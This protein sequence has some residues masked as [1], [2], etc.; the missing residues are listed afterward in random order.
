MA[1]KVKCKR[2]LEAIRRP[3]APTVIQGTNEVSAMVT[4][5][6]ATGAVANALSFSRTAMRELVRGRWRIE[7]DRID[8]DSEGRGEVLY[9]LVGHGWTFHF[10]LVSYKLPEEQK[11][12]R[13]FA[14]SWDAMGVLCQGEWTSERE[15]YLRRE[16][17]KQ[18]AGRADYDT[19]VYARGNRSGRLFDHVVESLAA[20]QQPDAEKLAQIG[21]ILRTTAFIGNGQLGTRPLAG[22][23]PNHPMRRP[24]H[25][26]MWSAF[27]LREYVFDLV[28]HLARVSNPKAASLA[29]N[30]RR[31]LGLGNSAAT[32]LVPFIVN[33]PLLIH[34]WWKARESASA[35][36]RAQPVQPN[37]EEALR[38]ERLLVKASRYF[39][40]GN[41]S[42]DLAFASAQQVAGELGQLTCLFGE[43]RMSGTIAGQ[44]AEFPWQSIHDW[45][46]DHACAE[47]SDVFAAILLELYPAIVER[48][49]DSGLIDERLQVDPTMTVAQLTRILSLRYPWA[50]PGKG[51]SASAATYFWY[52]SAHA[53]R[54]LRRGLRDLA[55]EFEAETP[56]DVTLRV[57]ELLKCLEDQDPKMQVVDLLSAH[58]RLRHIV[59]RVQALAK[60]DQGE[61]EVDF[62]ARDFSPFAAI[63]FVLAF[64][65]MEKF[66]SAPPKS[67]RGAF[68]QG[69]P[70]G[71]D[72]E[73]GLDGNW[74]FPLAP[75]KASVHPTPSS[76]RPRSPAQ[77][78]S[79][80]AVD[81]SATPLPYS[82]T[83]DPLVVAPIE[84]LR[85]LQNAL[86][87]G[88]VDLGTA[89]EGAEMIL[90]HQGLHGG[91][92][93]SLLRQLDRGQRH[94][95]A[96][97]GR[98]GRHT[99]IQD[100][101][102]LSAVAVAPI[103]LDMACANALGNAGIGLSL[104]LRAAEPRVVGE[105]AKRSAERGLLGLLISQDE[106][107]NIVLT[108]PGNPGPWMIDATISE[109]A[110]LY[111][112]FRPVAAQPGEP[113]P[114]AMTRLDEMVAEIGS[115]AG[116]PA[117]IRDV[118]SKYLVAPH[119]GDRT[120]RDGPSPVPASG[121]LL[122][123]LRLQPPVTSDALFA[124]LLSWQDAALSRG[125]LREARCW[126]P[127]ELRKV[128]LSWQSHGVR[129]PVAEFEALTS[130][131][132]KL[133]VPV[134]EEHRLRP[135][136]GTDPLK[137]F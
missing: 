34:S 67:V 103:A 78:A 29:A 104:A 129:I 81:R 135:G 79:Q 108:G 109:A 72:V 9:R 47:T 57:R 124:S 42:S 2:L 32:G 116:N 136:E 73:H 48:H 43:Y 82:G 71:E 87:A 118:L 22:F 88:G 131:A 63:R 97:A 95:Q 19:L 115:A 76:T 25:A 93:G 137:V 44:K 65:G 13:N 105:I 91:A 26:Q 18:R 123:C 68:L 127:D 66:E 45:L 125:S 52:R 90:F 41:P 119:A 36:A 77:G 74:P 121:F 59:G 102:D 130:A 117:G 3:I 16:I 17:P 83:I 20:G 6:Q 94:R 27:M 14:Q 75:A 92:V 5:R 55:P 120:A 40:E 113:S 35:S 85:L 126:S 132:A 60:L 107:A 4:L 37:D 39:S 86:Q 21:Y 15:A 56:M 110:P 96:P 23:E 50:L 69:A 10:F 28:D 111:D 128:Q 62:L 133:L 1:D 114:D 53:P 51:N 134:A 61:L 24:Y 49:A 112:L 101:A 12:D 99:W 8:L 46:S 54:D 31:Y 30:H 100:A 80:G 7:K 84:L 70:I 98:R 106:E 122:V 33:H 38:F 89:E 58:P 11:L 64:Y